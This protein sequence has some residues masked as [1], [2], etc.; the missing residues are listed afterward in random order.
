MRKSIYYIT[1][2]FIYIYA[3][4]PAGEHGERRAYE[5]NLCLHTQQCHIVYIAYTEKQYSRHIRKLVQAI[6]IYIYIQKQYICYISIHVTRTHAYRLSIHKAQ[7]LYIGVCVA[8][9]SR[10]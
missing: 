9:G 8:A 7:L 1:C 4:N 6:Y 2:C 3:E 10:R 5:K